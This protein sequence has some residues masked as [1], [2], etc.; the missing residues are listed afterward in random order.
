MSD[1]VYVIGD[2]HFGHANIIKHEPA[3]RPFDTI[4]EHD[5]ELVKRW[6]DVVRANDIVYHLGDA[7]FGAKN[8]PILGKL[9]GR[10]KLIL[11]NHDTYPMTEYLKYVTKVMAYAE[12]R[13]CLLSHMPVHPNQFHRWRGNI[14]GHMHTYTVGDPRYVCVSAERQNLTPLP[15]NM[16]ISGVFGD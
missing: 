4:E 11:G 8:L 9:N 7:V 14:H 5:A 16:V 2:T 10:I 12:Y 6:N 3:H 15:L 13:G 1:R